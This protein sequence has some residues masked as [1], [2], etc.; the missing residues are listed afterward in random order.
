MRNWRL[1]AIVGD[2]L[3]QLD[4]RENTDLLHDGLL[5]EF[6]IDRAAVV[7]ADGLCL[8]SEGRNTSGS[9]QLVLAEFVATSFVVAPDW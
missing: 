2:A 6:T 9:R 1:Y 4:T 3:L 7:P 5:H 8:R